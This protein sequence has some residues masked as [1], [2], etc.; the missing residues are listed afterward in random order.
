M[1]GS[2]TGNQRV[3]RFNCNMVAECLYEFT[4]SSRSNRSLTKNKSNGTSSPQ[5]VMVSGNSTSCV[6]W[7]ICSNT[8]NSRS[9]PSYS[10]SC[11]NCSS[12]DWAGKSVMA[13]VTPINIIAMPQAKRMFL[14][15][16]G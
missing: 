6:M 2:M 9:V 14:V 12:L 7:S 1:I 16:I 13:A 4:I 5:K 8:T 3:V 15:F 11:S 10:S